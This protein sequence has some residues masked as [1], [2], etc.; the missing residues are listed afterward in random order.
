MR[1]YIGAPG[2]VIAPLLLFTVNDPGRQWSGSRALR[3]R[4]RE[5]AK[6]LRLKDQELSRRGAEG[7][8]GAVALV[9]ALGEVLE[10]VGTGGLC[11]P[12]RSDALLD[13]PHLLSLNCTC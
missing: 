4:A 2:L 7:E 12:H 8:G 5:A 9:A 11:S 13:P 6:A 1:H 3:R 10:L